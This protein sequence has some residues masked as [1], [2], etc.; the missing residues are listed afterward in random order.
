M[1]TLFHSGKCDLYCLVPE[2]R[3]VPYFLTD[4]R[5]QFQGKVEG[6]PANELPKA[7]EVAIRFNGFHIFHRFETPRKAA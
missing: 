3:P 5:W 7:A 2:D 4:G 6:R 1:R